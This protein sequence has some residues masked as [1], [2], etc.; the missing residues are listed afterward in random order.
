MKQPLQSDVPEMIQDN[1]VQGTGTRR[2][3]WCPYSWTLTLHP[4]YRRYGGLPFIVIPEPP[5][6]LAKY[7]LPAI[8]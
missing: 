1:A 2:A 3:L 4:G 8:K 6:P 5:Q 7:D